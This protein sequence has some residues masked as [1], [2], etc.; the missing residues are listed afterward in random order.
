MIAWC[1]GAQG[2]SKC[3]SLVAAASCA[4]FNMTS[5]VSCLAA[6]LEPRDLLGSPSPTPR[7][8][9]LP[10][11][12]RR[13][14]CSRVSPVMSPLDS[15][16]GVYAH[17]QQQQ[18]QSA[19]LG[20][21]Q[22]RKYFCVASPAHSSDASTVDDCEE[23]PLLQCQPWAGSSCCSLPDITALYSLQRLIGAGSQSFVYECRWVGDT[24]IAAAAP[25]ASPAAAAAAAAAAAR[26]VPLCIK[27]IVEECSQ[28]ALEAA[29]RL[30]H[31]NVA[32]H[33]AIHKDWRGLWVVMEFVRGP[34]LAAYLQRWGPLS[35]G[36]T[37]AVFRQLIS[38]LEY[39]HARS[40]V[41]Q[42]VKLENLVVRAP[43]SSEASADTLD[44][45]QQQ[46][47][48][49]QQEQHDAAGIQVVLV[50]FG[51]AEVGASHQRVLSPRPEASPA[52]TAMYMAPEAFLESPVDSK[53]DVWSAGIVLCL[54]LAGR[55]PFEGR[56]IMC[57]L[58]QPP[59]PASS[60]EAPLPKAI[61]PS[62]CSPA[63]S[64]SP[65]PLPSNT[66]WNPQ[67]QARHQHQQ[68]QQQQQQ[69]KQ[70][71]QEEQQQQEA[72]CVNAAPKGAAVQ[73]PWSDAGS[74]AAATAAAEAP[75]VGRSAG[76][77]AA[78]AAD[79]PGA[80][81]DRLL[82]ALQQPE[83]QAVPAAAKELVCAMLNVD[84]NAR[85]SAAA[86]LRNSWLQSPE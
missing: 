9:S 50:D 74:L 80:V 71:E 54:L 30:K 15:A 59:S 49:Q 72:T 83:W 86:I 57:T 70:Q 56:S 29:C 76:A 10:I 23:A 53:S 16:V 28:E 39:I 66:T 11:P 41:H 78:A 18:Q 75:K 8:L 45:Q 64:I 77:A 17:Q 7:R 58:G 73:E 35:E 6:P 82:A 5:R 32:E 42:D 26:G 1:M 36:A 3:V 52:G 24:A 61:V 60:A 22:A 12:K 21:Q 31:P 48:Q 85:P 65:N 38:A 43:V 34:D 14:P 20:G 4:H 51:S 44:K 63:N 84:A 33:L 19:L 2:P 55:S 67:H 37:K 25:A 69:Q 68:Q 81:R 27:H 40:L 62:S 47:Q 79:G 46:Q 13:S